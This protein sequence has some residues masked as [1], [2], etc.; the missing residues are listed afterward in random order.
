MYYTL[1]QRQGLEV[2]GV[3]GAAESPWYVARKDLGRNTLVVV[4][5]HD[6]PLLLSDEILTEPALWVAG[7]PPPGDT[8]RCTVKTRYRQAD[9][10]CTVDLRPDGRCLVRTDLAQR[11]VTPGQSAVFYD[12]PVC[13][14][15]AVIAATSHP[16]A[17]VESARASGL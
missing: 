3:R 12:G 14:G 2:G 13:L 5:S 4:Q 11:A 7:S 8:L 10:A 9:Q 15:G 1:G 17:R 6:H 16:A